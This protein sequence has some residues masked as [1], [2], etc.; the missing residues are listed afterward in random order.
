M[1][2][3]LKI[4]YAKPVDSGSPVDITS[5]AFTTQTDIIVFGKTGLTSTGVEKTVLDIIYFGSSITTSDYNSA[6]IGSTI[7][8]GPAGKFYVKSGATTWTEIT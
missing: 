2:T 6:P 5:T 8:D 7:T 4:N 3:G 1:A